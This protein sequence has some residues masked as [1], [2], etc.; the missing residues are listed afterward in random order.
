MSTIDDTIMKS[1]NWLRLAICA[2]EHIR[3]AVL[4]VLHNDVPYPDPSYQGLPRDPHLLNTFLSSQQATIN[5]LTRTRILRQNQI[6]ILL[7]PNSTMT[8]SS[9]FDIPIIQL[10]I[11]QFT[12]LT[13]AAGTW[14]PPN[15]LDISKAAFIIRASQ[16]RNSLFHYA[17]ISSMAG[18]EFAD[19]WKDVKYVLNGLGYTTSVD[20]LKTIT[21]DPSN[22]NVK[23]VYMKYLDNRTVKLRSDLQKTVCSQKKQMTKMSTI[24]KS[25]TNEISN[26][27][28]CVSKGREEVDNIKSE[29]KKKAGWLVI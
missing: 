25:H 19:Y 4:D 20:D 21:L 16:L 10:L 2:S 26:I 18:T 6:D 3:N 1:Q 29:F 24:A 12:P 17:D 27:E 28:K 23:K 22:S 13:T 11:R 15:M 7:P 5:N 8:D 14:N 9:T